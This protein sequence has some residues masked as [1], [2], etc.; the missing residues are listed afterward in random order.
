MINFQEIAMLVVELFFHIT[1]SFRCSGILVVGI[2]TRVILVSLTKLSF[3][4]KTL[5]ICISV[6]VVTSFADDAN[7]TQN[8]INMANS[9]SNDLQEGIFPETLHLKRE[10]EIIKYTYRV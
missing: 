7:I 2:V 3:E 9:T 5:V 6:P 10:N 8:Q 4:G 1:C